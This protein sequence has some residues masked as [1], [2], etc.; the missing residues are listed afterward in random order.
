M[1][2]PA[3]DGGRYRGSAFATPRI[4]RGAA[5]LSMAVIASATFILISVDAFRRDGA[6]RPT[7]RARALADTSSS[8][9]RCCPIVHDPNSRE[10]REA[11]NLS[12][13]DER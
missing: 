2:W 1:R 7:I 5:S 10:G 4:G 11:L 9:S 13:L 3:T 8:S 6:S 12:V